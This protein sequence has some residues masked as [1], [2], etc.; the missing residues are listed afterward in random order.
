MPEKSE[1]SGE[2]NVNNKKTY[3]ML[4]NIP[5]HKYVPFTMAYMM[6]IKTARLTFKK[7]GELNIWNWAMTELK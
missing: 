2:K 1:N 7:Q 5:K 6:M 4:A 3:Q